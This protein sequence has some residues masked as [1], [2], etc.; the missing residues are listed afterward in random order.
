MST[1]PDQRHQ[2]VED[3]ARHG[4]AGDS[5][6][7]APPGEWWGVRHTLVLLASL[8]FG[9]SYTMRVNLSIA[10][11]DMVGIHPLNNTDDLI[12]VCPLPDDYDPHQEETIGDFAWGETTQ[13]LILGSFYYGFAASHFPVGRAAEYYGGRLTY[14]LGVLLCS[15]LT[16]LTPVCATTSTELFV[17]IRIA[18]GLALG[19]CYPAMNTMMATWF[20]P[21]ERSKYTTFTMTGSNL[22]TVVSYFLSGWL[23]DQ[24]FMGGW[25]LTFYVFGALGLA[26]S[27]A[28]FL[29]VCDRP[30]HHPRISSAELCFIK[31]SQQYMKEPEVVEIP[32]RAVVTSPCV[33]VILVATVGDNYGF[34][35]LLTDLPT[36]LANIQHFDVN[37][38]GTLLMLPYLLAWL[39]SMTWGFLVGWLT[40][41]GTLSVLRI[42]QLSQALSYYVPA[43]AL[44]GMCFISCNTTLAMVMLCVAVA[45]NATNF[46]GYNCSHQDIAPNLAG[47]LMGITNTCGSLMGV[48][49][50]AI[51]G[52]IIADNETLG[53]WRAV[54]LTPAMMYVVTCTLFLVFTPIHI[55]PWNYPK[56]ADKM[57]MTF[58]KEPTNEPRL[59]RVLF[60]GKEAELAA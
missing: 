5:L 51:T 50:P 44:V 35:T 20:T 7:T 48:V 53:A 33:W 47:T 11:V 59:P 12:D 36:Y 13:G 29:L 8:G 40:T 21:E 28:W 2:E 24:E 3:P 54:F 32:W 22:G 17:T 38:T 49:A 23:C 41:S 60:E 55:Q 58:T 9:V 26:W 56:P 37:E 14:G 43:L 1:L 15:L 16:L 45:L 25:P 18:Q 27:A 42:R 10:I 57:D 31:T 46:A 19:G 6:P 34:Y 39:M 52:V 30:E 4:A